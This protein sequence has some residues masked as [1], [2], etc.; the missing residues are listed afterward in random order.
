MKAEELIN[1]KEFMDSLLYAPTGYP[2]FNEVQ[3]DPAYE[4][5]S[6]EDKLEY[7]EVKIPFCGTYES[8]ISN[9][10]DSE[11][12]YDLYD[13]DY[14]NDNREDLFSCKKFIEFL[15]SLE[16]D[17][18]QQIR[19]KTTQLEMVFVADL[20][21]FC[22]DY[23][24]YI[25]PIIEH[26]A[27]HKFKHKMLLKEMVSPREY[28]FTTDS[29]WAYMHRDDWNA[30]RPEKVMETNEYKKWAS[31]W[32]TPRDGFLPF[33]SRDDYFDPTA[34]VLCSEGILAY[35]IAK[36]WIED[37]MQNFTEDEH[38]LCEV[39]WYLAD[40][41]SMDDGVRMQLKGF[42]NCDS[43]YLYRNRDHSCR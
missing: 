37:E 39:R 27:G 10:A 33:Y 30:I 36:D 11:V 32:Y 35:Y 31:I 1:D 42:E 9:L 7:V 28:N 6:Q 19:D 14:I 5:L 3:P 17:D 29:L 25:Q 8:T 38:D 24:E 23:L 21:Q 12:E 16:E 26:Q 22:R 34:T 43:F 41:A 4:K 20:N 2:V 18:I 40:Q 15:E 13:Q